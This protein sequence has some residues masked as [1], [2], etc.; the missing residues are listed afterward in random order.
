[1]AELHSR[2][3][4]LIGAPTGGLRGVE[5]DLEQMGELL[6]AHQF[7]C[8]TCVGPAATRDGILS[9]ISSLAENSTGT[10]VVYFAGHGGQYTV[11]HIDADQSP[12]TMYYLAPVRDTAGAWRGVLQVEVLGI[13][14]IHVI[15]GKLTRIHPDG[16][17]QIL[18][19]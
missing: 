13:S 7:H 1:M 10:T 18:E 11:E 5:R 15:D 2:R 14:T 17:Q 9:A 4:L 8:E 16:S 6:T 12:L 3:A 19:P